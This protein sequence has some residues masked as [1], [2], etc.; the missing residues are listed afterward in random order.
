MPPKKCDTPFQ[1][2][3]VYEFGLQICERAVCNSDAIVYHCV[4]IFR[5][6]RK[7]GVRSRSETWPFGKEESEVGMKRGRSERVKYFKVPFR[8]E[9]YSSLHRRMHSTQWS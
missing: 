8:R 9:N 5:G 1:A 4:T 6:V 2:H 7:G 3:H